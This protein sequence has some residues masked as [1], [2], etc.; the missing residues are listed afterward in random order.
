MCPLDTT[1][2]LRMLKAVAHPGLTL[3]D[4]MISRTVFFFCL[5][6]YSPV[7]QMKLASIRLLI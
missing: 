2:A 5:S 1:K 4:A 7:Y 6:S 3:R